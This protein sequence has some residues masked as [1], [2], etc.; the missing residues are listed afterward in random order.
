MRIGP[1]SQYNL[2]KSKST[3][4]GIA[5]GK[6]INGNEITSIPVSIVEG[7][8]LLIISEADLK[9]YVNKTITGAVLAVFK[10]FDASLDTN[11]KV[12]NY[13]WKNV[14]RMQKNN[15]PVAGAPGRGVMPQTDMA[16][17]WISNTV[18]TEA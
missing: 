1:I 8:N 14:S 10:E 11:E 7:R 3:Q 16:P 6:D 5:A 2:I 9:T 18:N 17:N 4:L 13:I 15:Q 12:G